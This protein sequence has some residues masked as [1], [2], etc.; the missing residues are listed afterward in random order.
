MTQLD[1][2][3]TNYVDR[4]YWD[5]CKDLHYKKITD[6]MSK[7]NTLLDNKLPDGYIAKKIIT[8][9]RSYSEQRNLYIGK[10]EHLKRENE[11]IVTRLFEITTP[12]RDKV[13]QVKIKSMIQESLKNQ[14][15]RITKENER[16]AR[17][18]S[19]ISSGI[20]NKKLKLQYDI[21]KK[22]KE[23]I[24]K[25]KV[26]TA[27][28]TP[29]IKS[30][31]FY[32]ITNGNSL[33]SSKTA[34]VIQLAS[35]EGL[36]DAALDITAPNDATFILNDYSTGLIL[37]QSVTNKEKNASKRH[38]NHPAVSEVLYNQEVTEKENNTLE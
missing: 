21:S 4:K 9:A 8:N 18:L 30:A 36:K 25:P 22:Y 6:I 3:D 17:R 37:D 12:R 15:L 27:K 11:R 34:E 31:Y 16:L 20:D 35:S 19:S 23:M 5:H 24:S 2:V 1:Y 33:N 14:E 13:Q 28:I 38:Y 10:K 26:H 7:P 32:K 29:K